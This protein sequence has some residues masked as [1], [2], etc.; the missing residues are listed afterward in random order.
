[1]NQRPRENH[2]DALQF[3]EQKIKTCFFISESSF[4]I[5]VK[6]L[7]L[8]KWMPNRKS[9]YG[10]GLWPRYHFLSKKEKCGSNNQFPSKLVIFHQNWSKSRIVYQNRSFFIRSKSIMLTPFQNRSNCIKSDHD[11]SLSGLLIRI[12]GV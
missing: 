3:D 5:S 1:M 11:H 12:N 8:K 10:F 4:R 7:I 2:G 6:N 9:G